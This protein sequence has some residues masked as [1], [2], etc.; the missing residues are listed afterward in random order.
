MHLVPPIEHPLAATLVLLLIVAGEGL[1]GAL[2]LLG[3]W[4]M[5]SSRASDQRG[6]TIAKRW[7]VSGAGI[8]V[9]VWF[10]LFQ[11]I[12]GALILMGQSEGLRATLEGAF[13]FAAYCFLTLIYLSLPE[14][15]PASRD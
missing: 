6:F 14:P 3:A 5:W 7:A 11:V 10:L 2:P 9:L 8:A 4:R 13:R 12:G 1:A 15:V